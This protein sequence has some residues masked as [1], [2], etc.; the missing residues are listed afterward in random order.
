MIY[1]YPGERFPAVSVTG[2]SCEVGCLYCEGSYLK[3]M[4]GVRG[5]EELL[6]VCRKLKKRG[7]AGVLVSGGCDLSGRVPLPVE[8]LQRVKRE[9]GLLLNVH[10]GC[11]NEPTAEALKQLDAFI[12]FDVPTPSRLSLTSL[13]VTQKDYFESLRLLEGLNVIPH[14]MLGLNRE[15]ETETVRKVGEMGFA[16]LVVIVLTP[17]RGTP[18]ERYAVKG[19][20]VA[21][22]VADAR[23]LFSRLI[24]G[25]M[26][27]RIRFL[28]EKVTLFDGIVLPT[29]WAKE[30][31]EQEGLPVRTMETC[32]VVE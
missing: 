32:C 20:E 5:E 25:C 19:E 16:S 18:L 2:P 13:K 29:R 28:E 21:Q 8:A 14:I 24:L 30:R 9:T 23:P 1:Y 11:V 10:A 22:T 26:R 15:E 3:Q 6:S 17:T 12:S 31:V 7:A 4:V 27:P